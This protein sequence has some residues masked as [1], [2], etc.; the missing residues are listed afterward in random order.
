[1]NPTFKY[2][3]ICVL[4]LFALVSV[5]APYLIAQSK[6]WPS[7]VTNPTEFASL[8][9]DYLKAQL[10]GLVFCGLC[11]LSAYTLKEQRT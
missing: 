1:M 11:C 2:T 7:F 9:K 5:V 6:E 8:F 10:L 4:V 3:L